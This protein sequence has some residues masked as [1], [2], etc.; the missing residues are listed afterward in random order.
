[1]KKWTAISKSRDAV[2]MRQEAM[3]L[4]LWDKEIVEL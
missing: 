3:G 4:F 1:L 2:I